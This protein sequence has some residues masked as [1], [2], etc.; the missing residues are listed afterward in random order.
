MSRTSMSGRP[1]NTVGRTAA[2]YM[3]GMIRRLSQNRRM[4]GIMINRNG[5]RKT[6]WAL[7]ENAIAN[8]VIAS[9]DLP[10]SD[11]YRHSSR[12]VV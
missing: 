12:N 2:R 11:A 1:S 5:K 8:H 9:S 6:A 10:R 3:P 7:T 4:P